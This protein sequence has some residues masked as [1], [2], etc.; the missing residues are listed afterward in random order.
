MKPQLTSN[1]ALTSLFEPHAPGDM[2]RDWYS[3]FGRHMASVSQQIQMLERSV[4]RDRETHSSPTS[5][6]LVNSRLS[7]VYTRRLRPVA[8]LQQHSAALELDMLEVERKQAAAARAEKLFK[9]AA[10][11]PSPAPG[12]EANAPQLEAERLLNLNDDSA[13]LDGHGAEGVARRIFGG[14]S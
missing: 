12:P 10:P 8:A 14:M 7:A 3:D 6:L 4:A 9:E 5:P 1:Q 11:P 13:P 2:A